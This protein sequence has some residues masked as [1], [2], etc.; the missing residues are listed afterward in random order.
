MEFIGI[1]LTLRVLECSMLVEL[2][3]LIFSR[4]REV[5][6]QQAGETG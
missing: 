6:N 3:A 4:F 5:L 2:R 1:A